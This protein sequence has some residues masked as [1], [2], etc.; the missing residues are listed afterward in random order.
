MVAVIEAQGKQYRVSL[1]DL[2]VVDRVAADVG[3][4]FVMDKVLY[5]GGDNPQF[6]TPCVKG[7]KV[8]AEVVS[9]DLGKKVETYKY[10]RTRRYRKTVGFRPRQ[11]TLRIQEIQV[12]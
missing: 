12:G 5:L 2:L 8:V 4:E 3:S 10:R 7:A 9:H 11:T 1:N 6:G